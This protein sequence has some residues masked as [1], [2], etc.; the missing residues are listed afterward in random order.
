MAASITERLRVA[1][2]FSQ[3]AEAADPRIRGLVAAAA[4]A[5]LTEP[6]DGGAGQ[7]SGI[8]H[9]E[10]PL[11]LC[12]GLSAEGRTWRALYD[13]GVGAA[14]PERR[15]ALALA[16]LDALPPAFRR[17]AGTVLKW[18]GPTKTHPPASF[19]YGVFW[20]AAELPGQGRALYADVAARAEPGH[21]GRMAIGC[22]AELAG[23]EGD[24]LATIQGLSEI[25]APASVG[26]ERRGEAK[27]LKFH[28]RLSCRPPGAALARLLPSLADRAVIGAVGALMQESG[29]IEAEAVVLEAAFDGRTG[30]FVD[31]KIDL[32]MPR[33]CP[34]AQAFARARSAARIL[35]LAW[36]EALLSEMQSVAR[37]AF[38][39]IGRTQAGAGRMN[40][41]LKPDTPLV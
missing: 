23:T 33:L 31:A 19:P 38:V 30:R 25:A 32:A 35:D 16:S 13:P 11:Q 27:R 2:S 4:A 17:D 5:A 1:R 20:L 15:H 34:P 3:A 14:T 36:P 12:F 41:Y 26:F 29:A 40:L 37:I 8:N 24:I 9:D 39:G 6:E 18:V 21:S 10:T 22:L 7:P 28:A